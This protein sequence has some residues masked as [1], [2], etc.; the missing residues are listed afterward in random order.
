MALCSAGRER[1]VAQPPET[2]FSLVA[3]GMSH[4]IESR[5][6]CK[7]MVELFVLLSNTRDTGARRLGMTQEPLKLITGIPNYLKNLIRI[8]LTGALKLREHGVSEALQSFLDKLHRF[9]VESGN[10]SA[11]RMIAGNNDLPLARGFASINTS[12]YGVTYG[13]R[14]LAPEIAGES[15]FIDATRDFCTHQHLSPEHSERR[16]CRVRPHC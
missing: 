10:P 1:Y 8:A 15:P 2:R 16:M 11:R 3:S 14:S 12:T 9:A 13:F 4:V 5:M 6:L 7:E